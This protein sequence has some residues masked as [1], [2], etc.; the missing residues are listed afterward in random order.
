LQESAVDTVGNDSINIHLYSGEVSKSS[1]GGDSVC[2]VTDVIS[3]SPS[4]CEWPVWL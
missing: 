1:G 4:Y 2:D 3:S